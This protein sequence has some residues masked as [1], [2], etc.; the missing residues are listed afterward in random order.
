MSGGAYSLDAAFDPTGQAVTSGTSAIFKMGFAGQ[1]TDPR[2]LEVHSTD[3]TE[4]ASAASLTA[5][6]ILDDETM[7]TIPP[8]SVTWTLV[9]GPISSIG[10]AG[11][12][13]ALNVFQ[14]TEAGVQGTWLTW[15]GVSDTGMFTVLNNGND[16]YGPYGRSL[17]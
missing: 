15:F 11:T 3:V 4:G 6:A 14:D 16:D 10:L 17:E 8:E 5:P 9:S 13:R 7:A 1:I 2:S 12:V